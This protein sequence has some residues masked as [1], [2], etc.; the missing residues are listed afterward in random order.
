MIRSSVVIRTSR[1]TNWPKQFAPL[2][3][4]RQNNQKIF[5]LCCHLDK[6]TDKLPKTICSS[7]VTQKKGQTNYLRRFAPLLS[8]RQMDRQTDWNYSF[9]CC[10]Q[11]KWTEKQNESIC[12]SVV[13]K[14]SGQTNWL[15]RFVPLLSPRQVDRQVERQLNRQ[16]DWNESLLCCH[17]DKKSREGRQRGIGYTVDEPLNRDR[18]SSAASGEPEEEMSQVDVTQI[19]SLRL[20]GLT[21]K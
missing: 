15:K 6:G 3:S 19:N 5:L 11:D 16:T 2:L 18:K 21:K 8:P 12:S 9:L 1:Q 7:F 4:S 13:T 10:Y 20:Y 17:L 14:T